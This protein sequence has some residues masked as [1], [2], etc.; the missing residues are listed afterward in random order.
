MVFFLLFYYIYVYMIIRTTPHGEENRYY[1]TH[2][3]D[4]RLRSFSISLPISLSFTLSE[5]Y[6]EPPL[7]GDPLTKYIYSTPLDGD[8]LTSARW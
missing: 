1:L 2:T 6:A 7:D 5:I 8:H 4:G 3:V